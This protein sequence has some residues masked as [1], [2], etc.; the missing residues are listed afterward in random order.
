MRLRFIAVGFGPAVS[1]DKSRAI[2]ES[3]ALDER[4]KE[5]ALRN[6]PTRIYAMWLDKA[7][8]CGWCLIM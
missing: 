1:I 4:W 6:N 2:F 5:L 7:G 3:L 8:G